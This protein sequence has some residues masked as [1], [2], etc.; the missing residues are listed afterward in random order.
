VH[1]LS[2]V[3]PRRGL[4]LWALAVVLL[5]VLGTLHAQGAMDSKATP[6]SQTYVVS[7]PSRCSHSPKIEVSL[8]SQDPQARAILADTSR[9]LRSSSVAKIDGLTAKLVSPDGWEVSISVDPA[10]CKMYCTYHRKHESLQPLTRI[11]LAP[12]PS[13]TVRLWGQYSPAATIVV[14]DPTGHRLPDVRRASFT[15]PEHSCLLRKLATV[16]APSGYVVHLSKAEY[17]YSAYVH[18]NPPVSA[19]LPLRI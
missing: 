9:P 8:D 17:V 11:D 5:G 16:A 7:L 13:A 19:A 15:P 1:I 10:A 6:G 12:A 3:R 2:L 4:E 14:V 18:P